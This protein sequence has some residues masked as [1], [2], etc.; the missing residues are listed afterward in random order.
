MRGTIGRSILHST[1]APTRRAG[2]CFP[3]LCL[4]L[5][6]C[7]P[8]TPIDVRAEPGLDSTTTNVP[9]TSTPLDAGPLG[10]RESV[11]DASVVAPAGT[12]APAPAE[13]RPAFTHEQLTQQ[14]ASLVRELRAGHGLQCVKAIFGRLAPGIETDLTLPDTAEV[15]LLEVRKDSELLLVF[16]RLRP[17]HYDRCADG[18]PAATL[19]VL[20][21]APTDSGETLRFSDDYS[22]SDVQF[23]D[24]THVRVA[25]PKTPAPVFEVHYRQDEPCDPLSPS[26]AWVEAFH[27]ASRTRLLASFPLSTT[28]APPGNRY[29]V[30]ST[31]DWLPSKTHAGGV[32]MVTS[33]LDTGTIFPCTAGPDG[34]PADGNE[35]SC[36][37]QVSCDLSCDAVLIGAAG[38]DDSVDWDTLKRGEPALKRVVASRSGES[39]RACDRL[40]PR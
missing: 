24:G 1:L 40:Q 28:F 30:T 12:D 4:M 21:V 16:L 5:W 36:G 25:F 32:L 22:A 18:G 27:R 11:T 15:D 17:E 35:A 39:R 13:R 31:L 14:L 26:R 3:T 20:T 38:L 2:A 6:A 7:G 9:R 37:P 10:A 19:G 34:G 23:F 33:Q 8:K 29:E